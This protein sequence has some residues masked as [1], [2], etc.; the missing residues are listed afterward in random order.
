M[1]TA[2]PKKELTNQI[3]LEL[4]FGKREIKHLIHDNISDIVE[5]MKNSF[6]V[7]RYEQND[8]ILYQLK[9]KLKFVF[10]EEDFLEYYTIEERSE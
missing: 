7:E 9:G 1:L 5:K 10:E 6:D 3:I 8:K 4:L 2:I